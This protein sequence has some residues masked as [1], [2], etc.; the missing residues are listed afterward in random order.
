MT[1]GRGIFESV[2]GALLCCAFQWRGLT[3]FRTDW[4]WLIASAIGLSLVEEIATVLCDAVVVR[5]GGRIDPTPWQ[6]VAVE[7]AFAIAFSLLTGALY[8][9][10]E[11]W[12]RL[13]ISSYWSGT[14]VLLVLIIGSVPLSV[15]LGS[16]EFYPENFEVPVSIGLLALLVY[17]A[18]LAWYLI[19]K[20][21]QSSFWRTAA[22]FSVLMIGSLVTL[23]WMYSSFPA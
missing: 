18:V 5:L 14:M 21:L 10:S 9:F 20:S 13:V 4:S 12:R 2:K 1:P 17:I 15:A 22:L 3:L 19:R 11:D 16:S 8:R 7:Y 6:H 23:G